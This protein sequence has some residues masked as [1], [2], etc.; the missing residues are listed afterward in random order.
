MDEHEG[1]IFAAIG[2]YNGG[3]NEYYAKKVIYKINAINIKY[4]TI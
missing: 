3:G 2:W 1:D 4:P